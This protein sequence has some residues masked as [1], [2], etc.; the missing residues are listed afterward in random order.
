MNKQDKKEIMNLIKY[1]KM[2][3]GRR[4]EEVEKVYQEFWKDIVENEDG[5]LNKEQV[6][7]ELFDYNKVMEN[8][9]SAYCEMTCYEIS[10]PNT[11]FSEVLRIFQE[12]FL[13]KGIVK[14]DIRD[15][16][17]DVD[18]IAALKIELIEYF[19]LLEVE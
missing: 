12:E 14:D 15:M 7:K 8:C 6:K 5:T 17:K 13:H 16:L 19:H 18:D 3:G 1:K 9:T 11:Y 4:M 2:L 10:N